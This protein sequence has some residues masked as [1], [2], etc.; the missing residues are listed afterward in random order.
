MNVVSRPLEAEALMPNFV[1]ATGSRRWRQALVIVL[2]LLVSA[3]IIIY[4][5]RTQRLG[6][7]RIKDAWHSP[8]H[9][10]LALGMLLLLPFVLTLRWQVLLSALHYRLRYR[11]LLSM[12]FMVVFFDT[13]MPGGAADLV[14]G[15][16]LDRNFRLGHRARALTTVIV[17]RFLGVMGLVLAAL[18]SLVL[19]SHTALAGTTLHSL[20]LGTGLVGLVFLLVFLFLGGRKNIGRELLHQLCLRVRVLKPLLTAYDAFR[21]YANRTIPLRQALCL[22]IVGNAFTITAFL[23]LGRALGESGLTSADYFCLV[24]L[25]LF[26]AQI[27]IS[28]GGIGVGHLGFYS[29]FR[30]AG[31]NAGAE[32]FSLFIVI[33]FLSSLPGFFCFL[34]IRR[35]IHSENLSASTAAHTEAGVER[36]QVRY[37]QESI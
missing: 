16:Y 18:A 19:K 34:L 27:P 23:L 31:S 22:S 14:R 30:M 3:L 15:Y 29:L 21:S 28:P 7:M 10:S 13:I 8:V 12:T 6:I 26:V 24:P 9:L 1:R 37:R 11:D 20:G 17:D 5:V 25:G 4:L 33:R 35:Q 36:R 2:K 32:I